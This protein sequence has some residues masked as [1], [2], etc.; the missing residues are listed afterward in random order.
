[1]KEVIYSIGIDSNFS[2]SLYNLDMNL[3]G[4]YYF[5]TRNLVHYMTLFQLLGMT[6]GLWLPVRVPS[7]PLAGEIVGQ[8]FN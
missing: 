2:R 1:M 6:G 4:K 3:G 8:M 5:I 7:G